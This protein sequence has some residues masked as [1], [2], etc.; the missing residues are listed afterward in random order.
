MGVQAGVVKK[1][2]LRIAGVCE[3]SSVDERGEIGARRLWRLLVAPDNR[4]RN[5]GEGSRSCNE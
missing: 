3:A 4:T 1:G 2:P 5:E